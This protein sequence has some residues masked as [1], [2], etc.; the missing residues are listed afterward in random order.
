MHPH[1]HSVSWRKCRKKSNDFIT[2]AILC[3]SEFST[4]CATNHHAL[5]WKLWRI[6]LAIKVRIST[7]WTTIPSSIRY[8]KTLQYLMVSLA[9]NIFWHSLNSWHSIQVSNVYVNLGNVRRNFRSWATYKRRIAREIC[10]PP[11]LSFQ[12]DIDG[13]YASGVFDIYGN[14]ASGVFDLHPRRFHDLRQQ[15]KPIQAVSRPD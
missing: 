6:R 9:V 14:Y 12:F 5:N 13:N 8:K 7:N 2:K 15:P 3:V 10:D 11:F 1:C 4:R